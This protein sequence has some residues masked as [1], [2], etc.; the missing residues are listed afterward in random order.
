[1]WDSGV[2]SSQLELR[3]EVGSRVRSHMTPKN[4][5]ARALETSSDL[6]RSSYSERSI[7]ALTDGTKDGDECIP[8]EAVVG[9]DK[10]RPSPVTKPLRRGVWRDLVGMGDGDRERVRSGVEAGFGSRT[11][12]R[13][14]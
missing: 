11:L 9:D 14:T 1:V 4:S 5:L 13:L 7:G 12:A 8:S 10:P 2:N 6:T 3:S